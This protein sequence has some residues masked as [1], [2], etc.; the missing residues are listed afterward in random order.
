MCGD[1]ER[2]L[3]CFMHFS[4]STPQTYIIPL[5]TLCAST[6]H[7]CINIDTCSINEEMSFLKSSFVKEK[8]SHDLGSLG[9][10][11]CSVICQGFS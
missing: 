4:D 11:I 8:I 10:T 3:I 7:A 2:V 6:V 1:F 9:E 5:L